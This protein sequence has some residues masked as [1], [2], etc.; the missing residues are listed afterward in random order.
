MFNWLNQVASITLANL[1][2]IPARKGAALATMVG[3]AGVVAVFVGVFAIA[4]GFHQA[5]TAS[6]SND[7]VMVMRSGADS[8]MSSNLVRDECR[9]ISDAP[10]LARNAS[11]P[12]ASAE[13]VMVMNV[14]K[15]STGTDANVPL[16]G[17]EP[18]AFA[19]RSNVKIVAGRA[20]TPG[21]NELN[22]GVGAAREFAGLELGQK[23]NFEQ[24]D[25]TIV[26]IF[27]A[28]GGLSESEIWAD[29][30]VLQP[31]YHKENNYQVVTAKLATPDSFQQ[32]KDALTSDPRLSVKVSRQTDYYADQSTMVTTFIKSIGI[33]IAAMMGLGALFGALNTMYSAVAA[34]GREI[35]TLRALGFGAGPVIMSVMV[36]SLALALTGG[37][38]GA[39]AAYFVF[40]G[41]TATTMNW[42]TF[43]QV[44]F[45]FRVTPQTLV[46]AIILSAII[47]V[48]GGLFPAIRAARRP[49]AQSL[50]EI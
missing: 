8:E 44:A 23:I 37:V 49:I 20:L 31:A 34:R 28:D 18:T 12:L 16:R 38:L 1:R 27:A 7:I 26:G 43:S 4:D 24:A 17:V 9:I 30:A 22:V 15:R 6:G 21:R 33:F 50:R 45:A 29:V 42:Q 41:F 35:A 19:V 10:G 5:M 47:G 46:S 11:G 39:A 36:E 2:T 3:I 32:L 14:P 48:C 40:N 25:W 13:V